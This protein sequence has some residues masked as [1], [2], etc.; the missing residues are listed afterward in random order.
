STLMPQPASKPSPGRM[1]VSCFSSIAP[2]QKRSGFRGLVFALVDHDDSAD[3]HFVFGRFAAIEWP[4]EFQF[5]IDIPPVVFAGP[6]EFQADLGV[7][8]PA[9]AKPEQGLL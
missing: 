6:V 4:V 8:L 1:P 3:E 5:D 2:I 9:S 7:G